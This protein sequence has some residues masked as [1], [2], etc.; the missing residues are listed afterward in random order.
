MNTITDIKNLLTKY[1]FIIMLP[2]IFIA[3]LIGRNNYLLFHTGVE[4]FTIITAYS[5]FIITLNTYQLSKNDYLMFIGICY[6]FVCGFDL[7]HTLSYK[8]M[9]IFPGIGA[10]MATQLWVVSRFM[11]SISLLIA[12]IF[13]Y[14]KLRPN[15][16]YFTFTIIS[17]LLLAYICLWK[18]FPVCYIEGAGLTS[19]KILSEYVICFILICAL[20]ILVLN[21]KHIHTTLLRLISASFCV[22]IAAELFFTFYIDVIGV[23]NMLGHLLRLISCYLIYIAIIEIGLKEPQ[24]NLFYNLAKTNEQ[25]LIEIKERKKIEEVLNKLALLDGL[26]GI[27]NRR[28]FNQ[29]LEEEWKNSLNTGLQL[30][31]ILCD[32]DYFKFYNDTYGHLSGDEAIKKVANLLKNSISQNDALVSRFGGEEFAVVLPGTDLNE[33]ET[34]AWEL[35]GKVESHHIL[36]ERS[37]VSPYLTVSMGVTAAKFGELPSTNDLISLADRAL[38]K[39]KNEGRNRVKVSNPAY[40]GGAA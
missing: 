4:L 15:I 1:Q 33:A 18:S 35:R 5:I 30:A 29:F 36:H 25:L 37:Q 2:V 6:G 17:L 11:E 34:I 40:E 39:A 27:A 32:I 3:V 12:P 10:N 20:I 22:T 26:T 8:G 19:F 21:K 14:K 23:L 31:L 28:Y 38:Y 16:A 7:L 13:F 9:G 24:K